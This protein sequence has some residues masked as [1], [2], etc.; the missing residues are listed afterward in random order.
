MDNHPIKVLLVDDDEDC[1]II[2]RDLLS[3]IEGEKYD[4]EWLSAYDPA[5]EV[6]GSHNHD[7]Y[8]LDYRLGERNGLELLK[9][10]LENGCKSPII[11]LT[12][13]NDHGV[14]IEALKAGAADYLLKDRIDV[15]ALERSIRYS[16]ERHRTLKAL[17]ESESKFRS[18][19]QSA[20]EAIITSDS[21]GN[22]ISWNR[23]AQTIFGYKEEEVL[24]KPITLLMPERYREA[25]Q[26]G[27]DRMHQTGKTHMLGK[28]IELHGLRKNGNEFPLEFSLATWKIEGKTFFSGILRDI[29]ERK[30]ADEKLRLAAKV[31]ENTREGIFVM[32]AKGTI[33]SV[34]SAFTLITGYSA[35]EAIGRNPHLLKLKQ[36]DAEFYKKMWE[37]LL[38]KSHWRGEIL[39]RRK[40]GEIYPE[41]LNISAIK[42]ENGKTTSYVAVF[43]DITILKKSEER[44]NYL[45]YH[46][47][48]TGLPNRLLFQDRI[49]Q[50]LAH[51]ER[52]KMMVGLL[53]IDLDRFKF[54]N[55]TLGHHIGDILLKRVAE[56]FKK[57]VRSIDTISRLGG[58]EFAVILPEIKNMQDYSKVAQ[59]ILNALTEV[60]AVEGHELFISASIGI[61][62]YPSD[63]NDPETLIKNADMSMYH[64]KEQGKNNYQF[65]SEKIN[66]MSVE[67]LKME[68]DLRRA[69]EKE[70]LLLF[71]QPQINLDSGLIVGME[72]LLRWQH[73]DRLIYPDEFISMAEET[74]LI[75]AIGEW[76]MQ[77]ACKQ[78]KAWQEAGYTPIPVAVNL[79]AQQFLQK[80]L[81]KKIDTILKETCLEPCYLELEL[82]ESIIMNNIEATIDILRDLS[83]KGIKLSIDDFG[84]GFSSLN[85]L[86]SFPID[87]LKIDQCFIQDVMTNKDDAALASTIIS[88]GHNL[89]IKVVAEGVETKDQR[90]FLHK[91]QCNEAQGFYFS[92][93]LPVEEFTK[94]LQKGRCL[95][96]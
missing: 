23:G 3:E 33:L 30:L 65:Y 55:D 19:T 70:E 90:A 48:L 11:I 85:Y 60:F 20:P 14:D 24:K 41:W 18:V 84:T 62:L 91:H 86:K 35:E 78:N 79:S 57:C 81:I 46:D 75:V 25:H 51:A 73:P 61:A 77:T 88:M 43:S 32:D 52:Y 72:A 31:F 66:V 34:N 56:R 54:I 13:Q 69:I 47:A 40:N 49:H 42:D 82:T 93:P 27:V 17:R 36:H 50:A 45:A 74:G 68:N 58:D 15:A 22:I 59:K 28:T 26:K 5:L 38:N 67:R 94:L 92:H 10:A 63:G 29:T 16:I 12:G 2:T 21:R 95:N 44:L 37:S 64:A 89:R 87:K 7:V 4:L 6:I 80:N 8:L 53:Y 9:E 83:A 76:V 1:Y 96:A 71:Y 39:N